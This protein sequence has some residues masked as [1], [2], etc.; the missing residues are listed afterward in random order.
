MISSFCASSAC[1]ILVTFNDA[2]LNECNWTL[3]ESN[4]NIIASDLRST[5]FILISATEKINTK[6]QIYISNSSF[7][8]LTISKGFHIY[9]CNCVINDR[10]KFTPTLINVI[11]CNLTLNNVTFFNQIKYDKG[12]VAIHS[13][14]S[15]INMENVNFSH[16]YARYG[17]IKALN[18]SKLFIKNSV[19]E[20][21]GIFML[22]SGVF[23]LQ[24]DSLLFVSNCKFIKNKALNGSCV[25]ASHN[26]TLAIKNSTFSS[27]FAFMGGAIFYHDS[28]HKIDTQNRQSNYNFE[29][30]TV[31]NI[32]ENVETKILLLG[33]TF[34]M[35][36]GIVGG[37]L[38]FE[39][40]FMNISTN[41]CTFYR[42]MGVKT[43]G[44]IF[45]QGK[46]PNTARMGI[47]SCKFIYNMS[48]LTGGLYVT[49][50]R[51]EIY[52]STFLTN[53]FTTMS[54]S[55]HSVVI[56]RNNT[57]KDSF[58]FPSIID[59]KNSVIL[60]INEIFFE[61]RSLP[62]I[63]IANGFFVFA[64]KN[65]SVSIAKS[66]FGNVHQCVSYMTLFGI[67]TFSN[68]KM[69]NSIIENSQKNILRVAVESNN[70]SVIFNNCTFLKS[71][72][73][74]VSHNSILQIINSTITGTRETIQSGAL[75]EIYYNSHLYLTNSRIL[76]NTLETENMIL[77]QF[78]SSLTF[79]HSLYAE[80]RM[81]THIAIS[82]GSV[83]ITNITFMNNTVL[84]RKYHSNTLLLANNTFLF[85]NISYFHSIIVDSKSGSLMKL[86]RSKALIESSTV[87][88][89][90]VK[91]I[92]FSNVIAFIDIDSSESISLIGT[93]FSS[94]TVVTPVFLCITLLFNIRSSNRH[95]KNILQ[96]DNCT[97]KNNNHTR[98]IVSTTSDVVIRDS[99]LSFDNPTDVV[100]SGTF[101]QLSGIDT[102]RLW[103]TTFCNIENGKPVIIFQYDITH[104]KRTQLLTLGSNF[105]QPGFTLQ[106]NS[107]HFLQKAESKNISIIGTSFFLQLYHEET[108]YAA[109]EFTLLCLLRLILYKSQMGI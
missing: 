100:N 108:A 30:N 9:I 5:T 57:I 93:N 86:S 107:Y 65:S 51:V 6:K 14:E 22:T 58:A 105:T 109:S 98:L 27:C 36:F 97:F 33:I 82:D 68:F 87:V 69:T 3:I 49:G 72:G 60:D 64:S 55:N 71:N 80:N 4:L 103:N 40:S 25:Q 84:E 46:I 85:I 89:N 73:F 16:N 91:C 50:T 94:N 67:D 53:Q 12:P 76:D 59:I 31:M 2:R 15:Q 42:N 95:S 88:H 32:L 1:E 26:I 37:A 52:N 44:A 61:S 106:S 10:R 34:N 48:F 24:Y 35:N 11:R 56:M 18:H 45:I 104:P 99:Y 39:G 38:Y 19:F 29:R 63:L 79:T 23:I 92:F 77:V 81:P 96:I 74:S 78:N 13:L 90:I 17:I 8:Q 62:P 41:D 70:A 47:Y 101:F 28:Y 66:Y 7:G 43:A 102:L 75:I 20:N 54:I 83:N 21:N